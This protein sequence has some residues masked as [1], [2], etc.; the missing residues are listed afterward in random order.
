[1][2]VNR[3]LDTDLADAE[4]EICKVTSAAYYWEQWQAS[5]GPEM[6]LAIYG[7]ADVNL[8]RPDLS[9]VTKILSFHCPDI[10]AE[11][12]DAIIK[13]HAAL[14]ALDFGL[15]HGKNTSDL[16]MRVGEGFGAVAATAERVILR[17]RRR[18]A[19]LRSG[20]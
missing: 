11:A 8:A 1:M 17:I 15:Q 4:A 20:R 9:K 5:G 13:F 6:A 3:S 2:Q 12:S 7:G 14:A 18:R 19:E 10:E 16:L